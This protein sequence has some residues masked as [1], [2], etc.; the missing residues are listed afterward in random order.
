MI[1]LGMNGAGYWLD[2]AFMLPILQGAFLPVFPTA[3]VGW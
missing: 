3:P 2:R 1:G